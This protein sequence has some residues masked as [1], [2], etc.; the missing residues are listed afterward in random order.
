VSLNLSGVLNVVRRH[1]ANHQRI[2]EDAEAAYIDEEGN[3]IKGPVTRETVSLTWQ[4]ATGKD[5][6]SLEGGDRTKEAR[7]F[8]SLTKT[9][10]G[11]RIIIGTEIFTVRKNLYWETNNL[12]GKSFGFWEGLMVR[13]GENF[14]MDEDA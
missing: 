10:L 1:A 4:P 13:S 7:K 2:V 5:L 3:S 14:N 11:D 8:W 9:E 12:N 6:D